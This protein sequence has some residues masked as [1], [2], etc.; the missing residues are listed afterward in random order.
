M[1]VMIP[2]MA[3]RERAVSSKLNPTSFREPSPDTLRYCTMAPVIR[4]RSLLMFSVTY[5]KPC[6]FFFCAMVLLVPQYRSAKSIK[7]NSYV[8]QTKRSV[9]TRSM[10]VIRIDIAV[11][12]SMPKSMK[13]Y[14]S[15]VFVRTDENPINSAVRLR[16]KRNSEPVPAPHPMELTLHRLKAWDSLSKS[17]SSA[18]TN[19]IR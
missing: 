9:A 16:F 7:L 8:Y 17:R 11:N 10:F 4:P 6:G 19:P 12:A 14:A 13:A 2:D 3:R 18:R 1:L 5:I 15:L